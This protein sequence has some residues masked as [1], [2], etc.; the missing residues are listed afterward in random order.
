[1]AETQVPV[2]TGSPSALEALALLRPGVCAGA[3][4][5]DATWRRRYAPRSPARRANAM[6]RILAVLHAVDPASIGSGILSA[7]GTNL[8]RQISLFRAAEARDERLPLAARV[9]M[10]FMRNARDKR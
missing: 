7:G 1:M 6:A 3:V 10:H 5:H 2:P 9:R 4:K 8:A